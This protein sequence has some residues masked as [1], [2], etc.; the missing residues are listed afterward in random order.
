MPI[1]HYLHFIAGGP[2]D[3]P[4]EMCDRHFN[5]IFSVRTRK[6]SK[7]Q[8]NIS[9]QYPQHK[10]EYCRDDSEIAVRIIRTLGKHVSEYMEG[11]VRK[12]LHAKFGRRQQEN[13]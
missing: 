7:L 3:E 11:R 13:L 2:D 5:A 1:S 6:R 9:S 4:K 8:K 10:L 12:I